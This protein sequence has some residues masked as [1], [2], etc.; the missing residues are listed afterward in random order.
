MAY[1]VEEVQQGIMLG[2]PVVASE[3]G[4]LDLV[5]V[6]VNHHPPLDWLFDPA[7]EGRQRQLAA[8]SANSA[9]KRAVSAE[10]SAR[11]QAEE[12]MS[13]WRQAQTALVLLGWTKVKAF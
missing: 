5:T 11:T 9:F 4:G 13:L 1:A 6:L 10:G 2:L 12:I 8:A 7:G 3:G